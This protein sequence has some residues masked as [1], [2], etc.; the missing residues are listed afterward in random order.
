M[1]ILG[2]CC[3]PRKGGNTELVL[4]EVLKGARQEGAETELYHVSG[5][6]IKPCDGCE[7]CRETGN[8]HIKD[9]MQELYVKLLESRGIIFGIPSYYYSMSG[10][11]KIII[12][13]TN[14]LGLPGKN[15]ANKVG[16]VVTVGGGLGLAGIMKDVYF[17]MVTK[18]MIPAGFFAGYSLKK[19]DAKDLINGL[20]AAANIGRQMVKIA[21]QG[22][23]YPA[24]IPP[25]VFAYGTWNK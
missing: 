20:K 22:F 24:D 3:S 9:D 6:N 10:Q 18:Q 15:L 12:D 16:S 21:E 2:L 23:E 5:K 17:Y 8:C 25:S 13:R 14:A 19:G 4:E 1:K 11:A 7:A